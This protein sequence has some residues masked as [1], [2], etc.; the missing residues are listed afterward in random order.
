MLSKEMPMKT[1]LK[2][3]CHI[4]AVVWDNEGV[5]GNPNWTLCYDIA[6]ARLGMM[7]PLAGDPTRGKQYKQMLSVPI[8]A[9]ISANLR[10]FEPGDAETHYLHSYT[11]SHISSDEFW[12]IVCRYG[13]QLEPTREHTEAIRTAQTYLL[14]DPNGEARV[15]PKVTEVL[16][17]LAT[18][19][20]QYL[21][22]NTNKEI[23]EGFKNAGF[24]QLI[25]EEHRFFSIF[26]KCRKPSAAAFE[27][28]I[29]ST[30]VEPG[31]ILFID[32]QASNIE[33]ARRCGINGILFSGEKES[34]QALIARLEH[35]GIIVGG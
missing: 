26:L 28:L 7:P 5:L 25:P 9:Q 30:G 27:A 24:L 16:A 29:A 12:P 6:Y 1:T 22:S 11:A 23:Y 33:A 8:T 3:D 31:A 10:T 4:R 2:D 35:F 32:D 18:V 17:A 19:L 14:K 21:L 34:E 20:P 15:F 13:F